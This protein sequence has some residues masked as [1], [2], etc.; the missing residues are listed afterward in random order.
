MR[1]MTDEEWKTRCAIRY[2]TRA[3]VSE[4]TAR[5][6]A[7]ACFESRLD[8]DCNPEHAADEDMSYL[9]GDGE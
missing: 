7:E 2:V 1:T 9:E 3:A 4:Q 5:D 8:D 6:F